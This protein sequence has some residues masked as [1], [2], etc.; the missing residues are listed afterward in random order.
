MTK[1]QEIFKNYKKKQEKV[2]KTLGQSRAIYDSF[3]NPETFDYQK[4]CT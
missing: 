2:T 1:L 3:R 4:F